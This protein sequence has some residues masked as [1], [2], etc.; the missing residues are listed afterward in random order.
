MI[1]SVA[2]GALPLLAAIAWWAAMGF[3][4]GAMFASVI[5]WPVFVL[6]ALLA[7]LACNLSVWFR[8]IAYTSWI[9]CLAI[10]VVALIL[11]RSDG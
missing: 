6:L 5:L 1:R 2:G 10:V 4:D 9:I 3:G 8:R 7:I 11:Q